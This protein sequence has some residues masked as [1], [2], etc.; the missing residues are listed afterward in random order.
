MI[1]ENS[2]TNVIELDTDHTPHLSMTA[3]L[4]DA[5]QKFAGHAAESQHLRDRL[6]VRYWRKANPTGEQVSLALRP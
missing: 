3:A 6:N 5:L 1:A 2:I 4:A